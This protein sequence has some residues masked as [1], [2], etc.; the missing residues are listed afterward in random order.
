MHHELLDTQHEFKRTLT[1]LLEALFSF[2]TD[3]R[4]L[5]RDNDA[6]LKQLESKLA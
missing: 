4:D 1:R 6:R 5:M 2:L 3:T